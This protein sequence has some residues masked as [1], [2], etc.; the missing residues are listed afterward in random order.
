VQFLPLARDRQNG[1]QDSDGLLYCS[2]T[3]YLPPNGFTRKYGSF[4]SM[5]EKMSLAGEIL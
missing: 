5:L 4:A 3:V 1:R 2:E